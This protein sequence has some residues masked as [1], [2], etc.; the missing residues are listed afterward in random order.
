[1]FTQLM[2]YRRRGLSL[3]SRLAVT[4]LLAGS[5]LAW[6]PDAL[7]NAYPD[8]PIGS[9]VPDC[10][11]GAPATVSIDAGTVTNITT[12]DL[13]AD[14]GTAIGDSSGGD[15]NVAVTGGD[16]EKDKKGGKNNH[17]D[18]K[19][20]DNDKRDRDDASELAASGNGGL[21]D[22]SGNGGAIAVENVNS[23]GNAGSAIGVGD[24]W[25]G[26]YDACGNAV[27]GVYIDG[28]EVINETI[29]SVSADGG[30]AIAD[31]S[32]GDGNFASTGGRAGNG[33][34][35][36]SSAGNGGI[37][38][39]SADGGA[40][41]IGDINSGGN[42]GNAIGVGDTIAGP[43]PICCEPTPYK[44][45]PGKPVPAPAPEPSKAPSGKVVI[46]TMLPS[47]GVGM[48]TNGATAAVLAAVA[49]GMASIVARRRNGGDRLTRV[50]VMS[51][52]TW[53]R[54]A[55]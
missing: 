46:V 6:T 21:S 43:I 4:A 55:G 8:Q 19:H 7:A 54:A 47:T 15:D 53:E 39:A 24:T 14:G 34:T 30:T 10:E 51:D 16:K 22:A 41:S 36:T 27:G 20:K 37:A 17:K 52:V 25:G 33:G 23:G 28:G 9:V 12:L 2:S 1:M 49:A 48:M 18:N 11:S 5:V 44:P 26:G 42:A 45:V 13:S 29:I 38:N 40:V 32:G 50:G 3:T 31:A 35:I